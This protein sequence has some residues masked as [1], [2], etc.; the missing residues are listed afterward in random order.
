MRRLELDFLRTRPAAAWAGWVLLAASAAFALDL[1][2]TYYELQ[3]AIPRHE[4]R[5]ARSGSAAPS[6]QPR[7][8]SPEDM[9]AARETIRRLATPWGSL[10]AA[11]ESTPTDGVA[12]LTVAPDPQSAS[13]LISGEARDYGALVRYVAALRGTEPL[14]R[15]Y[16]A[17]HETGRTRSRYPVAFSIRAPWGQ[18]Q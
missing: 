5:L 14:G 12:L 13:V 8:A 2:R 6:A 7:E 3:E 16:L 17:R 1:G 11:L 18:A 10:F 4:A 9:A 15:A